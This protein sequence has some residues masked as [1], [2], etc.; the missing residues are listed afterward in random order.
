MFIETDRHIRY[1]FEFVVRQDEVSRE[2]LIGWLNSFV[3]RS[4][5]GLPHLNAENYQIV[6]NQDGVE[7][8]EVYERVYRGDHE[9][10]S[11]R[12][13]ITS[14]QLF[15][16]ELT[17]RDILDDCMADWLRFSGQTHTSLMVP[18]LYDGRMR[19]QQEANQLTDHLWDRDTEV[20]SSEPSDTTPATAPA[21]ASTPA[22]APQRQCYSLDSVCKTQY[23]GS[24][25]KSRCR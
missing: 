13:S 3:Q 11:F 5:A 16:D 25:Q 6:F 22:P 19:T 23:Y 7:G 20:D 14:E 21:P 10:Y 17:D 8:E 9:I 2:Q 4:A 12:V 1:A 24:P 18:Q 15:E